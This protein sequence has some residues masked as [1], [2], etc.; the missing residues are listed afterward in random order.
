MGCNFNSSWKCIALNILIREENGL[1]I[2]EQSIHL[3]IFGERTI[4]LKTIEER[5]NNK[6]NL[7]KQKQ[8]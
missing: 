2:N 5:K 1:K 7:M 6:Q 3:K 4:Q 8:A